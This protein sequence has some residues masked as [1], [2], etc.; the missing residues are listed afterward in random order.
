MKKTNNKPQ[1]A[2]QVFGLRYH[3]FA[4]TFDI[5]EPF[6]SEKESLITHRVAGD[7]YL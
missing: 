2:M 4:D 6:Q 7:N 5:H 3:P 1:N